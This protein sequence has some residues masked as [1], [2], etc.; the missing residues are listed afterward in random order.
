MKDIINNLKNSN[1][2][3]IQLTMAINFISFKNTDEE[4]VM[5]SKSDK[6][7]CVIYDEAGE[8]IEDLFESLL[9]R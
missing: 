2:W 4:R 9:N 3:K 6:I 7:E 8:V 5:Q 1:A